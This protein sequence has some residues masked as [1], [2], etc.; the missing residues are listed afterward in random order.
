MKYLKTFESLNPIDVESDVNEFWEKYGEYIKKYD[1]KISGRRWKREHVIREI[2][3]EL[4]REYGYTMTDEYRYY[5]V[6]I[7]DDYGY[8]CAPSGFLA[9]VSAVNEYHA[10]IKCANKYY[11]KKIIK[12]GNIDINVIH[13][14]TSDAYI[15]KEVDIKEKISSVESEIN[16]SKSKILELQKKL[17]EL[18]KIS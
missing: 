1:E 2:T 9:T 7:S 14:L 4:I 5:D 8:T 3:D 17:E 6:C 16:D 11:G 13:L 15:A 10:K 18:K 12:R